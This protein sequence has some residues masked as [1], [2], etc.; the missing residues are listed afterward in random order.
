MVKARDALI[1]KT[2][3]SPKGMAVT[4]VSKDMAK[5][6]VTLHWISPWNTKG[7]VAV[8]GDLELEAATGNNLAAE[9]GS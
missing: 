7:A 9:R 4:V 8:D 6:K 1:G 2:Y 3:I 5:D